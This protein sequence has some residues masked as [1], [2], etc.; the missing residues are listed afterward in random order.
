MKEEFKMYYFKDLKISDIINTKEDACILTQKHNEYIFELIKSDKYELKL[1]CKD[2]KMNVLYSCNF[3]FGAYDTILDIHDLIRQ[4]INNFFYKQKSDLYQKRYNLFIV[5]LIDFECIRYDITSTD[6]ENIAINKFNE[7]KDF[8]NKIVN[9][10]GYIKHFSE[11][12]FLEKDLNKD[13]SGCYVIQMYD[14][15]IFHSFYVM[16]YDSFHFD[17]DFVDENSDD[18]YDYIQIVWNFILKNRSL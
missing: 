2:I 5:H 6:Y 16:L 7:Y 10:N 4:N 8:V 11:A 18:F 15:T 9:Y 13:I 12:D 3:K 14:E 1:I 17:K